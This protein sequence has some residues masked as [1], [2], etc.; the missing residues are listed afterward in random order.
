MEVVQRALGATVPGQVLQ[1]QDPRAG[2]KLID[3]PP[4]TVNKDVQR[5]KTYQLSRQAL[6][7]RRRGEHSVS[8][9]GQLSGGEQLRSPSPAPRSYS[10]GSVRHDVSHRQES[11]AH[12]SLASNRGNTVPRVVLYM[13]SAGAFSEGVLISTAV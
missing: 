10:Y 1:D 2:R 7:P 3:N 11:V 9:Y 12:S 8:Q 4:I 13:Q 5:I 6:A